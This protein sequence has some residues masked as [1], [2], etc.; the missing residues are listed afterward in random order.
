MLIMR[1]IPENPGDQ[2]ASSHYTLALGLIAK[3]ISAKASQLYSHNATPVYSK[4]RDKLP[5]NTQG[6]R[7][8]VAPVGSW[9]VSYPAE[10]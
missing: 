10:R 5:A 8:C 9:A 4:Y 1:I 6:R 2:G 7:Q 3:I